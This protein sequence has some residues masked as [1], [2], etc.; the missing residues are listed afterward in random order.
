MRMR[1]KKWAKPFLEENKNVMIQTPETYKGQWKSC[2]KKDFLAVEI[3]FGRGNYIAGM[4]KNHPDWALV[5]IE[6]DTNCA[7]VALKGLDPSLTNIK[8]INQDA[9][10]IETWFD[11]KEVDC[12]YLNFSDP[13]PKKGHSKRRLSSASFLSKYNDILS[14]EG[15]IVMK[16]D[17]QSLFEFSLISFLDFGFKLVEISVNYDSVAEG[18]PVSEYE[19]KF[20]D[21]NQPI[22]RMKLKK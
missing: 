18:D 11:E 13:W 22:Y 3:G 2:L 8:M 14:D 15:H 16:T 9:T 19:Q 6:K 4:A 10:V 17:N 20:L 21:L 5:G 7:A 12:I 1:K